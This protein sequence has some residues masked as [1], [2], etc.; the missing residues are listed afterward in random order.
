LRQSARWIEHFF[1]F[2]P[3][4]AAMPNEEKLQ[5]AGP[6]AVIVTVTAAQLGAHALAY[7]P[8][9]SVLWYLNLE[10]FRPVQYSFIGEG[11]SGLDNS[12]QLFWIV[13]PLVAMLSAG[14]ASKIRLPLAIASN[15][16]LLYGGLLL[17]GSYLAGGLTQEMRPFLES[18]CTPSSLLALTAL[19]TSIVSTAISHRTY[20]RELLP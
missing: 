2:Q 5:L 7:W 13:V 3:Q 11:I 18:L 12:G 6:I 20:W 16:S 15:I 4:N 19:L 17:Y 10:V 14:V 8:S 1:S 9:S